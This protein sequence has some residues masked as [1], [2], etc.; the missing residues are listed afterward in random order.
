MT[1]H[2]RRQ[3]EPLFSFNTTVKY[4]VA[5]FG[6]GD[7]HLGLLETVSYDGLFTYKDVAGFC[8]KES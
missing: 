1:H 6:D 4:Y 8:G 7:A 3:S 2:A 5:K